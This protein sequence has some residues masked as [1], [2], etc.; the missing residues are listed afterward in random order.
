[1]DLIRENKK[2]ILIL[3]FV[4]FSSLCS[5]KEFESIHRIDGVLKVRYESPY[6][7]VIIKKY[8]DKPR[9]YKIASEIIANKSEADVVSI[10]GRVI[11]NVCDRDTYNVSIRDLKLYQSVNTTKELRELCHRSYFSTLYFLDWDSPKRIEKRISRR[12]QK[13]PPPPALLEREMKTI[14]KHIQA[15][16]GKQRKPDKL[17]SAVFP[18]I[19]VI[20]YPVY[21]D[22]IEIKGELKP[23]SKIEK[24]YVK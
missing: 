10:E 17:L 7:W 18:S 24:L 2:A 12:S 13:W 22:E 23:F 3:F 8:Q 15:Y 14:N 19:G 21:G 5:A 11:L 20:S 16:E 4:I 6:L 1:M 9:I